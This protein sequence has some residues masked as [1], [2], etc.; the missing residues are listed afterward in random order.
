MVDLDDKISFPFINVI[1]VLAAFSVGLRYSKAKNVSKGIFSGI[2]IG[3]LLLVLIRSPSPSDTRQSFP[4]LF[5]A[6]LSNM[7]FFSSGVIGIITVRT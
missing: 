7:L 6:W 4:P 2:C 5:A 1:M 3:M